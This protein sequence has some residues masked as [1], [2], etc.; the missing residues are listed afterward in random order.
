MLEIGNIRFESRSIL[1]TKKNTGNRAHSVKNP[2]Q[3]NTRKKCWISGYS[4]ENPIQ[5]KYQKKAGNWDIR[6]E[7][8]P[9]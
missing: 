1:N 7:T 2:I 3:I 9:N 6:F 5:I 4:V 8:D